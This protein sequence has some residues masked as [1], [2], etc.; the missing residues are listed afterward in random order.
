MR[1]YSDIGEGQ[2]HRAGLPPTGVYDVVAITTCIQNNSFRPIDSL[3]TLWQV[4]CAVDQ[5]W[6][7]TSNIRRRE[8]IT[9]LGGAAAAWPIAAR[10]QQ[11]GGMRRIGVLMGLAEDDPEGRSRLA[12]LGRALQDLGWIEGHNIRMDY[13][14]AAGDIGRTHILATELVRSAPD[15]I[16]VNT[17]PG[18]SALQVKTHTIPIVF[19]QVLDASESA[20]VVNPAR[21]EANVTGF[22]NFYEYAISGKW[23][24]LLKEIAPSVRRVTVMQNPNHPSWVGYQ[25][26]IAAAAPLIGV[27]PVEARIYTP[28]DIDNTFDVMTREPNGGLLVLPDTFNTVHRA[29]IIALAAR[30]RIPAVYPQRFYATDG[31]LMAYGADLGGLLRLAA[32]YVDHILRGARPADLPVQSSSK[33]ELVIN[34]K[35]AKA[36]GLDGAADAA[37]PR[38]R[39]DRMKRREFI[40]LLGGAA[41]AWPL[42]ARAQQPA[43]P[44]I[45]FLNGHRRTAMR[46]LVG[47]R[48]GLK[49]TGY[50][51]GQNVAIEYRW[52][53][54]QF[55]RLPALAADLVRRQVR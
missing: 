2:A 32:S 5:L 1:S 31:G 8:F 40:T 16:V 11:S 51:E 26:S 30:H 27:Q 42:A 43:M 33:F 47:F 35:T 14:W 6:R 52:A 25:G 36:L 9:L 38:R 28:A 7:G 20:I 4:E 44:V 21:P 48:Q 24:S 23:L 18:L 29:K 49:E 54:G 13:R 41:A 12:T 45:G 50:V 10:A 34:L 19:V 55:D 53:E 46:S 15:A 17:P 3:A 39:G 37:R 22:T